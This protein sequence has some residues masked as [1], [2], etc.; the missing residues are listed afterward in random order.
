[1]AEP[2]NPDTV[3]EDGMDLDEADPQLQVEL[4]FYGD[5]R[6]LDLSATLRIESEHGN[7]V[8]YSDLTDASFNLLKWTVTTYPKVVLLG[9]I[10]AAV[11]HV[12]AL[13]FP[14]PLTIWA[15]RIF[16]S[17]FAIF[18]PVGI[19][20]IAHWVIAD[21]IGTSQHQEDYETGNPDVWYIAY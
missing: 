7:L 2:A 4:D 5:L 21:Q 6:E 8:V 20:D 10:Q 18:F 9:A 13:L 19:D 16:G 15:A 3:V 12:I 17:P 1:M 11:L 14:N